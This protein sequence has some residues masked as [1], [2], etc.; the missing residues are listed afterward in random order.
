[1]TVVNTPGARE[2]F[3]IGDRPAPAE[4][5]N[6]TLEAFRHVT[7]GSLGHLTDFGFAAGLQPLT[8]PQKVV[9][10]AFTVRIPRL[11]ATPVHYALNLVQ[12]GDVLV[13]DTCGERT[14]ACWGGVVAHAAMRAGVAGVIVDGPI[15][16]WEEITASGPPVWCYCGQTSSI[17]GRRLGLEGALLLPI[18]VGGAVVH[19]MD[20]VF[21]DSDGVFFVRPTGAAELAAT[22]SIRE[23]REP[24]LKRR[25]D[26]GEKMADVSGAA[27]T[28]AAMLN[29]Q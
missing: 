13:I 16:D 25:L 7:T 28:V 17:T 27:A 29:Q 14:R 22:L 12:P 4:E 10:P 21:A 9:G 24:E 3:V 20:I 18:Q 6:A 11:D 15:T 2:T 5:F 8:R 23:A 26:A 19:P 1:M